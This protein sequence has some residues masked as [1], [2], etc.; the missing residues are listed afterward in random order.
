MVIFLV[1]KVAALVNTTDPVLEALPD[2]PINILPEVV[3][4]GLPVDEKV[5]MPEDVVVAE[6]P[7]SIV[8]H[9]AFEISTVTVCPLSIITVSP[10]TGIVVLYVEPETFVQVLGL[11]QFPDCLENLLFAT[12]IGTNS[13]DDSNEAPNNCD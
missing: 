5:R 9:S 12:G 2:V 7:N 1:F 11:L 10:A 13:P 3:K 8:L 6:L 4:V